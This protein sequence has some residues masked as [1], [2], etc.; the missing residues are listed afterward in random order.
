MAE[1]LSIPT[2]NADLAEIGQSEPVAV[3]DNFLFGRG[4]LEQYVKG[5]PHHTDDWP[6]VEYF[7]SKLLSRT[8]SWRD[9]FDVL[10]SHREPV[11]PLLHWGGMDEAQRQSVTE[12]LETSWTAS[13]HNLAGHALFLHNEPEAALAEFATALELNPEDEEPWEYTRFYL[14]GKGLPAG[15]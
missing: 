6:A 12:G 9:N 1:L 8:W 10:L 2:V 15:M 14:A 5:V 3:L 7:S 4:E 13:T 11:I